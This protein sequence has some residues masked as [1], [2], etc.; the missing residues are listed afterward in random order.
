M[1]RLL[2]LA[3]AMIFF[4]VAFFAAIAPLLPDYVD[5]LGLSKAQAGILSASYAAGTLFA[6]LP[7]GFVASRVGPRRTVISGLLLLGVSS[8]LFGQ[9]DA[10]YLLDATRFTQGI[11]GALIWAGALT[12]LITSSP[13]ESRGQVI[14]TAL[15][16]AVAGALLGPALGALAG[17]IGTELVFGSVLL[18]T[19]AL[20]YAASRLPEARAPERQSLREVVATMLSKPIR[21]GA[22]FVAVPSVMFGA[23]EVLVPLRID[24]L[25][26]GHGVI[27]AGFIGGAALEATLAPIAGR[28]SDRVGRRLPYV[29]GLTICAVAMVAIALA[30]SLGG[31]LAAL[32]VTSLGAGLCFAPALTL[33]SDIA[34]SSRL[35][36]GFAAGLSN[37]AWASGQVV[38]GVGGGVIASLTGNAL[39]SIAI[40]A[41]LLITVAYAFH[42][43]APPAGA[44]PAES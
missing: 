32:I 42:A 12:W 7:A 20:A 33:L 6:S 18:V 25:G 10:I 14:G 30:A 9:V 27:A 5:Q 40:A 38:G 16:T 43:L 3:S 11:A 23:I 35:H 29:A 4:D 17:S 22:I 15:G 19:L 28:A 24:S 36:Q 21:D 39:P 34:E 41:L 2:W 37:M 26:G 8:L 13:E 44:Q 31:V 1:R